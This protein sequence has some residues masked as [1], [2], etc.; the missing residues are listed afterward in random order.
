MKRLLLAAVFAC[1]ASTAVLSLAALTTRAEAADMSGEM[2]GFSGLPTISFTG[3]IEK[4]DSEKFV[5]WLKAVPR[6]A[7]QWGGPRARQPKSRRR[8]MLARVESRPGGGR[9][10]R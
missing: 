10:G 2:K 3:D 4:G 8:Q 5:K 6:G 1:I 7:K 9:Y